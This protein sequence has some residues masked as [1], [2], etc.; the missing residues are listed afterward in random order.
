MSY[1]MDKGALS[2]QGLIGCFAMTEM[3]GVSL[4][5]LPKASFNH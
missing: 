2:L 5:H 4:T 1:W 3:R